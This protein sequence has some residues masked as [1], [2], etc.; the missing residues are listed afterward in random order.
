V[1][2][3]DP[4][5]DDDDPTLD[6]EAMT[7]FPVPDF[8]TLPDDLRERIRAE[9]ERAG[10][11]PNVF[12]AYAYAPEQFRA[13][14]DF[15]DALESGALSRDEVEMIVVTVSGRNHCHYC[16]VAHGALVRLYAKRPTLAD[17][18]I[19]NYRAANLSERHR[20]MLDVAVALTERPDA[21]DGDDVARLYEAG[22]TEREAWDVAAVTAFFNLSNRMATFADMRPNEEFH[23][24]GR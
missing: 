24:M 7:R 5:N 20:A 9:S 8:D 1:S 6:P 23:A 14:F 21:F 16:T 3:D 19:A 10:F 11:T 4:A 2:D 13:F 15:Y 12:A 22:F 18:L 17:E